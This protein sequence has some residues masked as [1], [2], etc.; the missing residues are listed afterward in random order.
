MD[1]APIDPR[2]IPLRDDGDIHE[3]AVVLGE[4]RAIDVGAETAGIRARTKT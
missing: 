2:A 4:T 1:G 3:V